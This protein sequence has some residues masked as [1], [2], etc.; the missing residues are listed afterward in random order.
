MEGFVEQMT[1]SHAFS[2]LAK[3]FARK[4]MTTSRFCSVNKGW[5]FEST[6]KTQKIYIIA[7]GSFKFT[8]G[9]QEK[10]GLQTR[11]KSVNLK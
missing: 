3:N 11:K 1:N 9:S 4:I 8:F 10:E 2:T 5:T 7:K 6:S